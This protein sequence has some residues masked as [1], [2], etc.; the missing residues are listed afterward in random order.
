M[1]REE[2]ESFPL[3]AM[4]L[5]AIPALAWAAWGWFEILRAVFR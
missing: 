2:R 3:P 5:V 4:W 1:G